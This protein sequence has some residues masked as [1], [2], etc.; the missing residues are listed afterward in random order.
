MSDYIPSTPEGSRPQPRYR[1]RRFEEGADES[2]REICPLAIASL[3][4]GLLS[5]LT[6]FSW[7]MVFIPIIGLACGAFALHQIRNSVGE[8]TGRN[9]AIAGLCCS[10]GLWIVGSG[11]FVFVIT[12]EVP[13]GYVGLDWREMQPEEGTQG[14]PQR[15]RELDGKRVYIKGY[16]YPGRQ[17]VNIQQFI[18]VPSR[19]HCK[20]C[21][22]ALNSTEMVKVKMSGDLLTNYSLKSTGVGGI[23]RIREAEIYRPL[24]GFPYFIEADYIYH[25]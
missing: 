24:G 19:Q 8:M 17:S 22:R 13:M 21:A 16:M 11:L 20:F 12:N 9:F 25:R 14:I 4:F 5:I 15:I 1:G 2:F 3:I 6:M 7:V 18:L 10:I 23:L